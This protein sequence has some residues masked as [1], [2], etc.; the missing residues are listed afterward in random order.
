MRSPKT[1]ERE[2][3]LKMVTHKFLGKVQIT[4]A[5][6]ALQA[7]NTDPS[8]IYV[9]YDDD[10]REVSKSLIVDFDHEDHVCDQA[11]A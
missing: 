6:M 8:T 3:E 11:K 4:E 10:I 5:C 7:L 1:D 9:E 2:M